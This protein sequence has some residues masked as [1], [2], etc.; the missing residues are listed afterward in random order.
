[1]RTHYQNLKVA[2][3]APPEVIKAAWR[4]LS[5]QYHP[6]KNGGDPD[7]ARIMQ[8][9]NEAYEVLIDPVRRARHDEAINRR[10]ASE[11]PPLPKSTSTTPPASPERV[12]PSP[13]SESSPI[14]NSLM[15]LALVIGIFVI[16]GAVAINKGKTSKTSI[17]YYRRA[18][19][20][21]PAQNQ[22]PSYKR[23][24]TAPNGL[25]WP[26]KTAYLD[27]VPILATAGLCSVTVDNTSRRGDVHI[28]LVMIS[29][30]G[31][32]TIRE[33]FIRGG[34]WFRMPV[35]S[36]GDYEIRYRDLDTGTAAR[37]EPFTLEQTSASASSVSLTLYTVQNGNTQLIPLDPNA[38]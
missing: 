11:L 4:A 22:P 36:P 6:D 25:L 1:M 9:L 21:A 19:T 33:A 30:N 35:V 13:A 12:N 24:L 16:M 32:Q 3:D 10:R 34:E 27:G 15:P 17:P 18:P 14:T 7:A 23:P 28:K 8:I 5:Q 26:V 38:F 29:N 20:P 31:R 2:E 37:S